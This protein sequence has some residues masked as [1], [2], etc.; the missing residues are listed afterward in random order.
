MAQQFTVIP[1]NDIRKIYA[2]PNDLQVYIYLRNECNYEDNFFSPGG[3]SV[4]KDETVR[5]YCTIAKATGLTVAKVRS[6]IK[7]LTDAGLITQSKRGKYLVLSTGFELMQ[8]AGQ[9]NAQRN[10]QHN[11]SHHTYNI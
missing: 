2:S 6:S 8:K 5:S 10:T 9:H 11:V 1:R 3:F 7:H 4:Q